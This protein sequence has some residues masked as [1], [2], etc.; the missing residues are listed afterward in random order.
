MDFISQAM[1][2]D[3]KHQLKKIPKQPQVQAHGTDFAAMLEEQKQ[4]KS[5]ILE[6]G[7][8][9][10]VSEMQQEKL[11]EEIK[12][13]I[14]SALGLTEEQYNALPAEQ[15]ATIEQA[16]QEAIRKEMEARM[17]DENGQNQDKSGLSVPMVAGLSM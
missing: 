8:A 12:E 4:I 11:E 9:K 16:I 15:R 2:T 6:K 5:E 7:F 13:K 3:I 14:L 17:G 10:Y 1:I